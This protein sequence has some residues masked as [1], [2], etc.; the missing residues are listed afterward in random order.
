VTH[1]TAG[2]WCDRL[3]P[4][5]LGEPVRRPEFNTLLGGGCIAVRRIATREQV[6]TA[7]QG[8]SVEFDVFLS[9]SSKDKPAADAACHAMETAKIRCWMAPRDILPGAEWGASIVK[10]I[11]GAKVM[12]LIFSGNANESRQVTREVERAVNKGIPVIPVRIQNIMPTE[13]LEYFLSTPHWLDAFAPPIEAHFQ[14]LIRSINALTGKE[15]QQSPA[16][17]PAEPLSTVATRPFLSPVIAPPGGTVLPQLV[18]GEKLLALCRNDAVLAK[19]NEALK[20]RGYHWI[21]ITA[22]D[23]TFG[24][25]SA[26]DYCSVRWTGPTYDMDIN[27]DVRQDKDRFEVEILDCTRI[28]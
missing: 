1:N 22:R 23:G 7:N 26:G 5:H 6:L 25:S 11:A 21:E 13:S 9:Y 10:A 14:L 2:V 24:H 20:Q 18:L 27:Y 8:C 16:P 12:V 15:P 17:P 19:L 28:L 3:L 4:S